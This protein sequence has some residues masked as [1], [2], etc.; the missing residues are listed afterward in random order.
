M[1]IPN[2]NTPEGCTQR[3]NF[4]GSLNFTALPAYQVAI[5]TPLNFEY[6]STRK[7][8]SNVYVGVYFTFHRCR[9]KIIEHVCFV[10][11]TC[12]GD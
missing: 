9:D 8:L 6:F 3:N 11:Y 7:M 2:T 1:N 5:S 4:E 12:V 10:Y